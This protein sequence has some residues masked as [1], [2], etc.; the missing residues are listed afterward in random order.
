MRYLLLIVCLHP[1]LAS[2]AYDF[3]PSRNGDDTRLD[4]SVRFDQSKIDLKY[5]ANDINTTVKRVGVYWHE[6]FSER[7]RLGL[8]GGYTALTQTNS[9]LTAGSTLEGYHA[10][11][12]LHVNLIQTKRLHLFFSFD[13]AYQDVDNHKD[14]QTVD[15]SW[16]EPNARLGAAVN[17]S[18]NVRV[19][20]GANYGSIDGQERDSGTVNQT[21]DFEHRGRSGGFVG[22]DLRLDE[23]GFVGIA[24]RSGLN[25]GGEIYF[26]KLF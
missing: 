20:G 12:T 25:R 6:R 19:F 16:T 3:P 1:V 18:A 21:V 10:G 9:P 11:V 17:L 22:A 4:F 2:H 7:L 15:I 14:G 5:G 26:K 23:S 8:F 24:A 13:Y